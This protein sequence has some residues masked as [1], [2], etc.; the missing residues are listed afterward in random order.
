[1]FEAKFKPLQLMER[2]SLYP[3]QRNKSKFSDKNKNKVVL[4]VI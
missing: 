1:M 4:L 2:D 3:A